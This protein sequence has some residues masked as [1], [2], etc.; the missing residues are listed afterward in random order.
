MKYFLQQAAEEL[1]GETKVLL[2]EAESFLTSLDWPGNVRQLENCCRW[3]TVMASGREVHLR[4][5]PPELGTG[6]THQRIQ[7]AGGLARTTV[8]L[9]P[10]RTGT[11]QATNPAGRR[12]YV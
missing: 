3:I 7:R 10:E 8:Q 6:C 5:L 9:G 1:G 12:T 2:P 4:D 11:G